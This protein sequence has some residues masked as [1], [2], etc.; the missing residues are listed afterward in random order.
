SV[1]IRIWNGSSS[2]DSEIFSTAGSSRPSISRASARSTG[3]TCFARGNSVS[4]GLAVPAVVAANRR[5]DDALAVF[6]RRK[7]EKTAVAH[8]GLRLRSPGLA[9]DGRTG[10]A[11]DGVAHERAQ[12]LFRDFH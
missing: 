8:V 9:R 6:G 11:G 10:L 12:F 1:P 2:L 4:V 7:R 3:L 5:F